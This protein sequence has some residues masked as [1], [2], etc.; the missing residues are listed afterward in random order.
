MGTITGR[1]IS[2]G[3]KIAFGLGL[4]LTIAVWPKLMAIIAV[5]PTTEPDDRSMP[6]MMITCVTPSAMMPVMA[7]CSAMT[8]SRCSLNR[9]G[10]LSRMLKRKLPPLSR[11]RNSKTTTMTTSARKT[12]SSFGQDRLAVASDFWAPASCAG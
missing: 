1:S 12:L 10:M 9:P 6:P 8:F 2:S 7:T 5:A 11:F 4:P 3:P